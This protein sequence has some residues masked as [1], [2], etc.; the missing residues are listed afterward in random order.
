[1]NHLILS[2]LECGSVTDPTLLLGQKGGKVESKK[3]GTVTI[4]VWSSYKFYNFLIMNQLNS[5]VNLLLKRN[6][7]IIT[8]NYFIL[9]ILII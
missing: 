3:V 9:T 8:Y 5:T 1:M 6:T 2:I 7:M 4:S